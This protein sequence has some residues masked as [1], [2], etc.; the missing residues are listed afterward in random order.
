MEK[1]KSGV[2]DKAR[3]EKNEPSLNEESIP[4]V[5]RRLLKTRFLFLLFLSLPSFKPARETELHERILA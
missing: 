2:I 5:F 3:K 1:K 4:P